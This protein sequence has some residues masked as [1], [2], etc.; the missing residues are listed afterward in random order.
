MDSGSKPG[1]SWLEKAQAKLLPVYL[2]AKGADKE[3]GFSK[4]KEFVELK[5]GYYYIS[6][7]LAGGMIFIGR[8]RIAKRLDVFLGT[9]EKEL[10]GI[11]SAL[12]E[13]Q[14]KHKDLKIEP[15][16]LA[17]EKKTDSARQGVYPS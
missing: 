17:F 5:D 3:N 10:K 8:E 6:P 4:V 14:D 15:H 2:L 7:R 9:R 1:K 13:L 16:Y 12:K 11:L